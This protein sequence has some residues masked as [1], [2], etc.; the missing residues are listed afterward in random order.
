MAHSMGN[1]KT[2]KNLS[3]AAIGLFIAFSPLSANTGTA[4][5]NGAAEAKAISTVSGQDLRKDTVMNT[6]G[7]AGK[8]VD[9]QKRTY[10]DKMYSSLK[11]WDKEFLARYNN[12]D[13]YPAIAIAFAPGADETSFNF[14]WYSPKTNFPGVIQYA[15]ITEGVPAEFPEKAEVAAAALDKASFGFAAHEATITGIEQA[16]E[17]VYRLGDGKGKWSEMYSFKTRNADAYNFLLMGDPQIG[18][19]GDV[20]EDRQGWENTLNKAIEKF[21]DAS[22][23]QSAGDQVDYR[24]SEKEFVAYFAPE[25]LRQYPTATTIGNHDYNKYY[26]YHFNVPNQNPELGNYDNSGGDYYFTYGDTLIMNLNSNNDK[27][28]EHIQFMNETIEATADRDFKWKFVVFHHSIYSAAAHSDAEKVIKL[29]ESLVP[30]IDELD[31]D[32]VLMG[33][34]HSYVRTYQMKAL[35][36]L[37]NHMVQN[38]SVVNPEGTVYFTANSSSGSKYYA[39]EPDPEP[40]AAVRNQLETTT[41]TNVAVTATSLEFTT[42]RAD[43]ME[44][45]DSYKIIKDPA[46]PVV[47][48]ALE[49]VELEVTGNVLPVKPISLYPEVV[50]I[51]KGTNVEGAQYDILP[52][53]VEYK[54]DR[55]GQVSFAADGKVSLAE[56][57]E[58]GEVKVWAEVAIEGETFKTEETTLSIV[59]QEEQQFIEK[60]SEWS[61]LDDGSD[62]GTEWKEPEFDDSDWD[63]GN[64]PLGYPEDEEH[65]RFGK[66]ETEIGYGSKE[67]DKFATSYFR[68]EFEVEDLD[69][70]GDLGFIDFTVDD[71]VIL[72][73]N[74]QEIGR[75][76]L[77]E[78]DISFDDYLYDVADKNLSEEGK[79]E[80]IRLD[81][82]QLD[83]LVEG[84]NVL[85]AEVHQDDAQSS[86]LYWDMELIT[87]IKSKNE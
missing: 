77:P 36:P 69:S 41:F 82:N 43:T 85:A 13:V 17:Y 72:Y 47:V 37:K 58:L 70:I 74:G 59:D 84:R 9:E 25:A 62:Q 5:A 30:A 45:V 75:F 71:S 56:N 81:E 50:L 4:A 2:W 63:T 35:Q 65:E 28:E 16:S 10:Q 29:R 80:R 73:L 33:H 8:L 44:A 32:A 55:E 22:F 39:I 14:S 66:I 64:A 79:V 27:A 52:E 46:I 54:A 78:G 49:K 12:P 60:N 53:Q 40:Y 86:D 38:G 3:L 24:S 23:I 31:I 42:Y 26:E 15:K 57:A 34:D 48:P 7:L 6:Y 61:Y 18:A 20:A 21:P 1:S 87:A 11:I 76:N 83:H 68:T 19:S 67:S 51:V